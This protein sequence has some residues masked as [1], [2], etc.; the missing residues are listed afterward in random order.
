MSRKIFCVFLQ[1]ESEGHEF[2]P[3]PGELGKKI[4]YKI[5]KKAWRQW[6]IQQTKLINEEKLNMMN[7]IDQKKIKK[8]M[9]LFLFKNIT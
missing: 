8:Y 5:S 3:Y 4:Y 7:A 1:K 6:I 9:Q 2:P